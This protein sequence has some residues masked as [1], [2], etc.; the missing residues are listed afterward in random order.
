MPDDNIVHQP[1]YIIPV[2]T[3]WKWITHPQT[4]PMVSQCLCVSPV[5]LFFSHSRVCSETAITSA[6]LS[7]QLMNPEEGD[8]INRLAID[9]A[10]F[11]PYRAVAIRKYPWTVAH[12]L[13]P[14]KQTI[15]GLQDWKQKKSCEGKQLNTSI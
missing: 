2:T 13:P 4:N 12:G 15:T 1:V 14:S 3:D 5:A 7:F 8:W 6:E 10:V 9:L 11:F